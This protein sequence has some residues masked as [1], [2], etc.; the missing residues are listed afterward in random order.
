MPVDLEELGRQLG[1]LHSKADHGWQRTGVEEY[2]A[3]QAGMIHGLSLVLLT[4]D[5]GTALIRAGVSAE[6]VTQ[7]FRHPI[8]RE[9][10]LL[11][12]QKGN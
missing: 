1:Y 11:Q 3:F 6:D 5:I 10:V 9:L 12:M 2:S 4:E 7:I 8:T